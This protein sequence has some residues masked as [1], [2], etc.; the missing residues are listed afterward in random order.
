MQSLSLRRIRNTRYDLKRISYKG[1]IR[2]GLIM[3]Y[4]GFENNEGLL[5]TYIKDVGM[6]ESLQTGKDA[7]GNW[8][9]YLTL[10]KTLTYSE[11]KEFLKLR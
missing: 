11:L 4:K 7:T 6:I 5:I 8:S 10:T 2:D 9:I 1:E 3:T